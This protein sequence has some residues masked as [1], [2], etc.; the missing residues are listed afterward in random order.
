MFDSPSQPTDLWLLDLA[1]AYNERRPDGTYAQT[2]QA[3]LLDTDELAQLWP[4]VHRAANFIVR[5]GPVTQQDRWEEDPGYSPFTLAVE[6][7]GLLA[8]A[9]LADANHEPGVAAYLRQTADAW[10]ASIERWM[11]VT[12]TGLSALVVDAAGLR[13][14]VERLSDFASELL[15]EAMHDAILVRLLLAHAQRVVE[16]GER[17]TRI[18]F[19]TDT[20]ARRQCLDVEIGALHGGRAENGELQVMCEARGVPFTGSGSASSHLAFDKTAA[21]GNILNVIDD[22]AEQTNLLA[23][24]AAIL[25]AQSGEHGKGFAVVADEI[26]DLAER[27]GASTKEISELIR[28]VQEQ[29]K[30]AVTAMHRGVKNVE[31]GVRL[32]QDAETALKKIQESSQKS[33]H[34]V[35]AI[36]RR[37]RQLLMSRR[38]RLGLWLRMI[39]PGLTDRIAAKAVRRNASKTKLSCQLFVRKV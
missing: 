27:T 9:D 15:V 11:Y 13:T 34:M 30:N 23:L 2:L 25:A 18:V 26:K 33:T 35:K 12:G 1:D 7:T 20:V 22:V 5:N 10:N 6:I 28:A 4:M 39:A 31:E 24:N 32:G 38:T 21:I 19:A 14:E 8:A 16:F 36:A 29:S 17:Q 3:G 37:D